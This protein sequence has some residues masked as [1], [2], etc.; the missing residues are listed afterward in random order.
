MS[1]VIILGDLEHAEGFDG[2]FTASLAISVL[3]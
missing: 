3:T 1:L 2:Q